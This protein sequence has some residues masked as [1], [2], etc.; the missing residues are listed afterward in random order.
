DDTST[1][2]DEVVGAGDVSQVL[3][4]TLILKGGC[5]ATKIGPKHLLT[6]ARCVVDNPAYKVGSVVSYKVASAGGQT[7]A[8]PMPDDAGASP[9]D[10]AGSPD[11][12]AGAPAD[13]DAS[14]KTDA[15]PASDAG[16]AMP[17]IASIQIHPSFT[18]KCKTGTCN[19]D[20]IDAT[21]APDVAV[22]VLASELATVPTVP[23]DLDEVGEGDPLL[24]VG[25]G[26][27]TAVD[28]TG[29]KVLTAKTTAVPASN[30]AHKGG[31]YASSPQLAARVAASYVVT[32][33]AGW[34][35]VSGAK[36]C[37]GDLGAPAFRQNTAAVTGLF[38][39][40]T[41]RTT[42]LK[43]PVT[44]EH[45]RVDQMS[46]FK[47]GAWLDGLG[48]TT[49]HSCSESAN[50]CEKHAW[51]GG[52]PDEGPSGESS[53]GG[54]DG[55]DAM[56]PPGDPSAG[57]T[58]DTPLPDDS[59]EGDPSAD[60]SDYSDAAV[61]PKKSSSPKSGCSAAPGNG[62]GGSAALVLGIG[63]AMAA[64]RRRKK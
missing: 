31:P 55:G 20:A 59:T 9:D 29:P 49:T 61:A 5:V 39:N 34:K 15:G 38:S 26:C 56:A 64:M 28:A 10:D 46:R 30:V 18:Q 45:T 2:P 40:Y 51:S 41:S 58:V 12:D 6:A 19:L 1:S 7:V 57:G 33:G 54:K 53:D 24:V 62:G 63:L 47:I 14:A 42:A 13:P 27:G 17:T 32:P 50:G 16:S 23:V 25:S 52:T 43:T 3:K 8:P 48:A 44:I 60:T 37:L 4:S 22:I 21:D 36:V 35:G 11:D